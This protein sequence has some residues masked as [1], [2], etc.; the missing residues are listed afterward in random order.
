MQTLVASTLV[1]TDSSGNS[2]PPP[3]SPIWLGWRKSAWGAR[4]ALIIQPA[5]KIRS[6]TTVYIKS[7][8]LTEGI[9]EREMV[10]VCLKLSQQF[11][12]TKNNGLCSCNESRVFSIA[13]PWIRQRL[14]Y[15][16]GLFVCHWK[17]LN[18]KLSRCA[19]I[20]SHADG[21][22]WEPIMQRDIA[23]TRKSQL[24]LASSINGC[25]H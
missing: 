7:S 9:L 12:V 16:T 22:Y 5:A 8:R 2:I 1:L 23:E 10:L 20:P 18:W 21:L 24:F 19:F 6:Q 4:T 14:Q 11:H 17:F 3:G 25:L 15:A 13:W